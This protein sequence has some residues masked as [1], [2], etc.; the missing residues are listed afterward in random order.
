MECV[1]NRY[2]GDGGDAL[3]GMAYCQ[4]T[5]AIKAPYKGATMSDKSPRK[6]MSK[7]SGK[8]LK[9]KR[10]DKAAKVAR[11]DSSDAVEIIP[12]S[13]TRTPNRKG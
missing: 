6:T 2:I 9:E 11:R 1:Y 4:R 5:G 10:A 12:S 13:K 3:H 8:T 7:K